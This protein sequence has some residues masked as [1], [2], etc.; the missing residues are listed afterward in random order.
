MA[1]RRESPFFPLYV[2]AFVSDEKLNECSATA[3]GVYIR[4]LCLMHKSEDY[5]RVKFKRTSGSVASD[6]TDKLARHLPY[7]RSEILSGVSELLDAG[8]VYIEGEFLCQK[9]MIKDGSLSE[10]RSAMGKRGMARRW[11]GNGPQ[12]DVQPPPPPPA[13]PAGPKEGRYTA[14]EFKK[15]IMSLEISAQTAIDWMANRKTKRLPPTITAFEQ[16]RDELLKGKAAG[17]TTEQQLKM[18]AVKGWGGYKYKW[19]INELKDGNADINNPSG[20][21]LF[22]EAKPESRNYDEGM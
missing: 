8:V 1:S 16:T 3:N 19:F 2:D 11:A 13:A 12:E 22:E 18:A 17:Y 9:R 14:K 20:Y 6:V 21:G 7:P 10:M 4:V 5:G 15:D